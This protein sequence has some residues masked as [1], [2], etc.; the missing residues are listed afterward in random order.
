MCG[1]RGYGDGVL[2]TKVKKYL[3]TVEIPTTKDL[4]SYLLLPFT[5]WMES[6]KLDETKLDESKVKEYY[7]S[8]S[9]KTSTKK[10][11]LTVLKRY[12]RWYKDQIPIGST[13]E[14]LMQREEVKRRLN[15]VIN[16]P[17]PKST[18]E[19][20]EKELREGKRLTVPSLDQ[21]QEIL[22]VIRK[23]RP[24]YCMNYLGFYFGWRRTEGQSLER[25]NCGKGNPLPYVRSPFFYWNENKMM[26]WTLKSHFYRPLFFDNYT[27]KII[28]EALKNR[29][30]RVARPQD[31][32]FILREYDKVLGF[33]L[34]PKM[35]RKAFTTHM[36]RS[37]EK[38]E[39][40]GENILLVGKDLVKQMQ[41]HAL[42]KGE[43]A[44][45][46]Y[47]EFKEDIKDAFTSREKHYMLK[48]GIR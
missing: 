46:V 35:W 10:L 34:Y 17:Q 1:H 47:G 2:T 28:K 44:K 11:F 36:N 29:Y 18:G 31:W 3:E 6:K 5:E 41:G 43:D 22:D 13:F 45:F 9:W 26:L 42:H 20:E 25:G 16:M 7:N 21:I 37:L 15:L 27:K 4:K 32:N 24:V 40:K 39:A 19:E 38:W 48:E 8:R 30:F 14:E 33:H 23:R 12:L